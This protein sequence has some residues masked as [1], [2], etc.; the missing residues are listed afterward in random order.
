[1]PSFYP[2]KN[3]LGFDCFKCSMRK[4]LKGSVTM[5]TKGLSLYFSIFASVSSLIF[6]LWLSAPSVSL[7]TMPVST[8][9]THF[10]FISLFFSFSLSPF[11]FIYRSFYLFFYLLSVSLSISILFPLF[12]FT[13]AVNITLCLTKHLTSHHATKNV[14][15]VVAGIELTL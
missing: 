3:P 13:I 8:C 6:Y 12:V 15:R 2:K 4:I 5:V 14:Y 1:M 9:L 7:F 10:T 11:S